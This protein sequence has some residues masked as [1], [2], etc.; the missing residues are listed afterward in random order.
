[1]KNNYDV[2]SIVEMKKTHPCGSNKFEIIRVG[3]DIK[4]KCC[5]CGHV[6]M[7]DRL[8]FNKKIKK[9]LEVENG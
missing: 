7:L 3:V 9:V 1:M 8:Q 5:G 4:I 6:I 2:G